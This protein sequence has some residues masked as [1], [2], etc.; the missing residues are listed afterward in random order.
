M[1]ILPHQY[2]QLI[3]SL[4]DKGYPKTPA[5]IDSFTKI[6]RSDFLPP[7]LRGKAYKN[8][9][10]PIG[11]G[12]MTTEPFVVAFMLEVLKPKKGDKILEIGSGC[13]WQ[14]A[15]I[16]QIVGERGFVDAIEIIPSLKKFGE[17]NL[18]KYKF[19]NVKVMIGDGSGGWSTD[20]P[21]DGIIV[22]AASGEEKVKTFIKQLEIGARLVIPIKVQAKKAQDI[23]VV[24]RLSE[25]EYKQ[26]KYH[27]FNFVEMIEKYQQ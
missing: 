9:P 16:A 6:D 10:L 12:Q 15:L 11:F 25:K 26:K 2:Q 19:N 14:T 22:T 17:D 18:K 20:A 23:L 8:I 5:I 13:G 24:E 1:K 21:Y 4:I 27:G 7:N 3:A